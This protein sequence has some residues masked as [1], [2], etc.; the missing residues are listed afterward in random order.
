M[1]ISWKS[2]REF[3]SETK[4]EKH[5]IAAKIMELGFNSAGKPWLVLISG[6]SH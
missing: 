6:D 4:H 5:L 2:H 3:N 1:S